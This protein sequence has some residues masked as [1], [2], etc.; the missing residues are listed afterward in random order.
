M[1]AL[2]FRAVVV[3]VL[4]C[5]GATQANQGQPGSNQTQPVPTRPN[6]I[7]PISP[8]P[9]TS[10]H[11]TDRFWLPRIEINRLVTI[12]FAF[13]QCEK[14]GRLDH[15]VRA[16]RVLR[17]EP[18]ANLDPPGYPFDDT[19]IYKVIEGASYTLSVHPDPKLESYVD[20]LIEKIAAAQEPDGYLY[21][22]RTIN[23]KKP[24]DWAGEQ[25]WVLEKVDSHELY[26]LGHLYEAAA[27]HYQATGK[28]TLLE[29]A[30]KTADLL[31]ATFG[32]GKRAIW[33]GHQIT[34]MGLVKLYRVTGEQK[35][36]DLAKFLLDVRGPDG[37][38]GA[39]RE[40]NQSHVP[41]VRQTEAVGHAVRATY[42]YS[43]M[44]DVAAL[45]GDR[46]YLDA[47]DRIWDSVVSRKLYVTGGIGATGRGEAFGGPYE[48][49]NMSAYNETCAAIGNDYWNHR[50]FLLHGDAKYIDVMERT[51][52][53]GL[54]SGV[55]L[56]G[57]A[58]FYPNPLESAGQHQRSPWF[59][60]A[61][62]PSNVTR[63]LASVPGY[64][65]AVKDD[66]IF[67]NLFA[68]G[69]AGITLGNGSRVSLTQETDY[70][71]DG[72]IRIRVDQVEGAAEFTLNLRVPGWTR[73][74]PVPSDLY[75]YLDSVDRQ[76]T[77]SVN[78]AAARVAT[79]Q[80]Y[81][82]IKRAWRAGDVIDFGLPMPVRRIV[83]NDQVAS[84]RGRVALQR[85]PVVFAVE[86]PDNPGGRVRNLVLDDKQALSSE[87]RPALLGGVQ[88]IT[89]RAMAYA[90]SAGGARSSVSQPFTAIPYFAWA[91]RGR[92][93]MAVW[94][95]RTAAAVRPTPA[96]TLA[97]TATV[98]TSP[99]RRLP[100]FIND[101]EEPVSSD[102]PAM[103]FDWWPT[104]GTTEWAELAL[105]KPSRV[106]EVDVYW[107][108][109]TG[110]GQVRVPAAWRVLY[111]RG[112]AWLP[113][114]TAGPFG[115]ARDRYNVVRFTP[116]ETSALR[117]EVTLQKEW[118]AGL[119]EWRV[120]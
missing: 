62:C 5:W 112:D 38:A 86:W 78:G 101:G 109:D 39:G 47:S 105:A 114:E 102:D 37:D 7:N 20:G 15:F 61:C 31:L 32:P 94:I 8:V 107:F 42:M 91:N 4:I 56:D 48:L 83:A 71:W 34:E 73:N 36:L 59:G 95:A 103:Y 85:G 60:V 97:T 25:R 90:L 76:V 43:G 116:V 68:A 30:I 80:G 100:I 14:T 67:V 24:H 77:L 55:S 88:V 96:P 29:I 66:R 6:P 74:E 10:V 72:A 84:D 82:P 92:G 13:A 26:N 113:V 44:A 52:Y 111:R 81:V 45:T 87:F 115:V 108:D 33:P 118:S 11:L 46:S 104:K 50:L 65:Y 23:P 19:D 49:P 12:P 110:H 22:T 64:V 51:L 27:A 41:V 54:V 2:P 117:L 106:S 58:F 69:R 63:F 18:V 79:A 9:F 93:E 35:Y 89:G 40:Y 57:Q 53:N 3:L 17:G 28:R 21:T 75:R 70:P 16:A 120:R 119:Q 1:P 99:S 98:T